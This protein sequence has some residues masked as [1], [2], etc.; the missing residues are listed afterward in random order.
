M[1]IQWER[2]YQALDWYLSN[3]VAENHSWENAPSSQMR[4]NDPL[5]KKISKTKNIYFTAI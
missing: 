4:A 2:D 1:P 3:P 5:S